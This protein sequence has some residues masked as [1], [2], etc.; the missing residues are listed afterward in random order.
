M[1]LE[2]PSNDVLVGLYPEGVCYLLGYLQAAELWILPFHR[3]DGSDEFLRGS[4]GSV[5]STS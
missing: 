2:D 4:L 3:H 1:L 5:E